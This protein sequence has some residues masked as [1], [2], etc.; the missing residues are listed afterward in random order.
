M[1]KRSKYR[2][3]KNLQDPI[4]WVLSGL[5]PFNS[6]GYGNTLRI[7]NHDAM[8]KLR[9]GVATKDDIDI[10]IGAFNMCEGY[11]RLRD[12]LGSDWSEEIRA[13]QDALLAVARRGLESQHFILKAEELVAMNLVME[14]HDAQL[15]QTTVRDMELA[16]DIIDKDH[17][18]KKSRPIKLTGAST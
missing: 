17:K 5:K 11:K 2:P 1:R 18:T 8:D 7:R 4:S 10:L 13:G 6:V 12:E 15:D 14:I 9:R 16:M 3:K